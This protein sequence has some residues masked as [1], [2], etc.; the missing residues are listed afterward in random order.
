M[1]KGK[2]ATIDGIV[3]YPIKKHPPC[4]C[5]RCNKEVVVKVYAKGSKTSTQFYCGDCVSVLQKNYKKRLRDKAE[6]FDNKEVLFVGTN[7]HKYRCPKQSKE[8]TEKAMRFVD[9]GK[10]YVLE[11]FQ[12]NYCKQHVITR[13]I[14]D[15]N[16]RV[17]RNYKTVRTS[18]GLELNYHEFNIEKHKD[19]TKKNE[20][21]EIPET[22]RWAATHPYQGGGCAPR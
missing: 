10:T 12:C 3:F 17:L 18:T 6:L 15:A 22:V 7:E 4:I 13:K 19:L 14:Y 5:L 21:Q 9:D 2:K 8:F 20:K 11:V 16:A 1:K